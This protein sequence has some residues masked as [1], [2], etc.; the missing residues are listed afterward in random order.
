MLQGGIYTGV[1]S[2]TH[3]CVTLSWGSIG[4][5]Y[6]VLFFLRLISKK[7]LTVQQLHPG[8]HTAI[9]IVITSRFQGRDY[10][11]IKGCRDR[12]VDPVKFNLRL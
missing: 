12:L 3:N 7:Q 8:N 4:E 9:H 2:G 6:N 10:G 11:G 1:V 5:E